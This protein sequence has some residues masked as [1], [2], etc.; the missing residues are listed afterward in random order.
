[1]NRKR[2]TLLILSLLAFWACQDAVL[3]YHTPEIVVE[4]WIENEGYPVVMLTTTVPV[5]ESVKDSS[6]LAGHIIR[7]GKVTVSDGEKEVV[8]A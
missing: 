8:L 4:G 3:P 7:W 6:D 5:N 2:M 1:M